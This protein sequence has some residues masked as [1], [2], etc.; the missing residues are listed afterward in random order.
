MSTALTQRL[1][2]AGYGAY[3][4]PIRE[5]IRAGE[6]AQVD[7]LLRPLIGD[8]P[9][10]GVEIPPSALNGHEYSELDLR[11]L[12]VQGER[13]SMKLKA[14]AFTNCDLSEASFAGVY[15]EDDDKYWPMQVEAQFDSCDLTG[16]EFEGVRVGFIHLHNCYVRDDRKPVEFLSCRF[17]S[18]GYATLK[19][20]GKAL[21]LK[22]SDVT[23][24][25]KL[26]LILITHEL[27]KAQVGM[28][29]SNV[30]YGVYPVHR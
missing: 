16:F 24:K 3:I 17:L 21:P 30:D 29:S 1:K 28:I 8:L 19:V 9:L 12:T 6:L 23:S 26:P 18:N 7:A 4:D 27:F 22:L 5:L 13:G 15:K 14:V 2:K 11:G 20:T 10:R 25:G